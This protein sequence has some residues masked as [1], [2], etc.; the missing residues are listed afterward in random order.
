MVE[1]EDYVLSRMSEQVGFNI[2]NSAGGHIQSEKAVIPDCNRVVE[3]SLNVEVR[4]L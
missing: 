2:H 1:L 3:N 4:P